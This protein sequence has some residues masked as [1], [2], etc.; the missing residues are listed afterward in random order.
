MGKRIFRERN[1]YSI[2]DTCGKVIAIDISAYSEE[3]AIGWYV[4]QDSSRGT[5]LNY[6]AELQYEAPCNKEIRE[7]KIKSLL[8]EIEET[9]Y[10]EIHNGE[11]P[12]CRT[13]DHGVECP[14]C[15]YAKIDI[16]DEEKIMV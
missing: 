12:I 4:H 16:S 1:K 14:N 13:I 15:G 9:E 8:K 2:K 6:S 5:S 3:Q 11:C 10:T 7:K